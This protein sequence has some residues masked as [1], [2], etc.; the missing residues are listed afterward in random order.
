MLVNYSSSDDEEESK[1]N[2]L[3]PATD[4]SLKAESITNTQS[5]R[6]E[7]ANDKGKSR[8]GNKNV[9]VYPFLDELPPESTKSVSQTTMTAVMKCHTMKTNSNFN[10]MTHI[11]G[12]PEFRNPDVLKNAMDMFNIISFGSHL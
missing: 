7:K 6:N 10:L 2:I 12:K 8:H 4:S 1:P 9:G 3:F 11:E 5:N